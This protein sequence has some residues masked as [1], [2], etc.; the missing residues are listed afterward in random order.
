MIGLSRQT[1]WMELKKPFQMQTQLSANEHWNC[2]SIVTNMFSPTT[3]AIIPA[4]RAAMGRTFQ[5]F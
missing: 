3:N 4:I 2:P 1:T 5:S